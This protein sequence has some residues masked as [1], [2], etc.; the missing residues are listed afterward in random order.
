MCP[1][2]WNLSFFFMSS[3]YAMPIFA[4]LN[5]L[6]TRSPPPAEAKT[7]VLAILL[8]GCR[9]LTQHDNSDS[10]KSRQ[11]MALISGVFGTCEFFKGIPTESYEILWFWTSDFSQVSKRFNWGKFIH[12]VSVYGAAK[13]VLLLARLWEWWNG[14]EKREDALLPEKNV[15]LFWGETW[16]LLSRLAWFTTKHVCWKLG[17]K[18]IDRIYQSLD[19]GRSMAKMSWWAGVKW[20]EPWVY[21][22]FYTS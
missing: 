11:F 13:G 1:E 14:R 8:E 6:D 22:Q 12:L 17:V 3:R 9:W 10:W 7:F 4:G 15:C 21:I 20:K 2:A 19:H 18:R 5:R 16:R